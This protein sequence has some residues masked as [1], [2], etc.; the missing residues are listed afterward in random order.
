MYVNIAAIQLYGVSGG[1]VCFHILSRDSMKEFLLLIISCLDQ[2]SSTK[3][4]S[5]NQNYVYHLKK[6]A[7]KVGS[8]D[9][10]RIIDK[11]FQRSILKRGKQMLGKT[12][13]N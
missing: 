12:L 1:Y 8:A 6:I 5:W 7:D 9:R 10:Q 2:G 11:Y 13:F 4:R 3:P